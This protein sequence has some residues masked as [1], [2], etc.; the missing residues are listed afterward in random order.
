EQVERVRAPALEAELGGGRVED[1]RARLRRMKPAHVDRELA[2]DEHPHV[3]VSV[4]LERLAAVV[5]KASVELGGEADVVLVAGVGSAR[6]AEPDIVDRKEEEALES[7][8]T[9][10]LRRKIHVEQERFVDAGRVAV[11]LVEIRFGGRLWAE[12]AG[13]R[14]RRVALFAL[15]RVDR[16]LI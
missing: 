4:E 10:A 2:V 14:L 13:G 5:S 11:P 16:F 9:V 7:E 3:V 8:E 12:G 15:R 1:D 6:I